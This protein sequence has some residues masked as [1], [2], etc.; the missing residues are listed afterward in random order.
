VAAEQTEILK[1]L[2]EI[3]ATQAKLKAKRMRANRS[4]PFGWYHLEQ[5][6]VYS[7]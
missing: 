3:Q 1:L 2:R 6:S 5:F 7:K 4:K